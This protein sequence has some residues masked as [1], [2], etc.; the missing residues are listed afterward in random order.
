MRI[1]YT[2]TGFCYLPLRSV[3]FCSIRYL[4]WTQ[5]PN[6]ISS[7]EGSRRNFYYSFSL[8]DD[9]FPCDLW[10]LSVSLKRIPGASQGFCKSVLKEFGSS[11]SVVYSF[12]TFLSNNSEFHPLTL[13]DSKAVVL[14]SCILATPCHA[15]MR[16]GFFLHVYIVYIQEWIIVTVRGSVQYNISIL[17]EAKILT[18]WPLNIFIYLFFVFRNTFLNYSFLYWQ[19]FYN[20]QNILKIKVSKLLL[21]W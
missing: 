17:F 20:V 2:D 6:W 7:V 13:W 16:K 11:P 18:L 3:Y 19:K 12:W 1:F 8:L 15:L 9:T 5:I 4:Y 10:V 14:C 21:A